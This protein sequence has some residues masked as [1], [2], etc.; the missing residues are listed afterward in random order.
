MSFAR[1]NLKSLIYYV[2]QYS[3]IGEGLF[4]CRDLHSCHEKMKETL[5]TG[6]NKDSVLPSLT[7]MH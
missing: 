1:F 4:R 6:N 3:F 7:F 2:S 5:W